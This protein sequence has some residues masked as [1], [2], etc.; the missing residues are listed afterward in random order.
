MLNCI[1]PAGN[2]VDYVEIWQVS[3][4]SV[5]NSFAR[6]IISV[7]VIVREGCSVECIFFRFYSFIAVNLF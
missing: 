5:K 2:S 4:E 3:W 7:F 1:V 6:R